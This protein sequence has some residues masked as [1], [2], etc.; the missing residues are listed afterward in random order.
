MSTAPQNAVDPI[1]YE[2]I[3]HRLWSI[4]EEGATTIAHASG[5]PVVHASDYNFGI[6]TRDGE[7]AVSG[8]FYMIPIYVMQEVIRVIRERFGD[9]IHPGDVFVINDPFVAGVHQND[10]QFVA[11][12]FHD[13]ELVG[14][15]GCMAHLM[16]VG[17]ALP[18]SWCPGAK[19]VY[20][21]GL[22]VPAARIVDRG[23]LV[24]GV[25]DMIVAN[26]RLPA[27]VA[28]DMSAFLSAHRVAQK[29]LTEACE[30]YGT[31][32]IVATLEQTLD[33]T[34]QSMREWL[35]RLPDGR[36][37]HQIYIDHDGH[38][39]NLY[40]IVCTLEKTGDEM[41]FDFAGTDPAIVGLGNATTTG[42]YGS[43]GSAILAIFGSSLPWNGGLVRPLTVTAPE[44]SVVSAER[45]MPI[46]AGSTGA[47]YHVESAALT[48]F[49]KLLAFSADDQ[50]YVCGPAD[51]SWLLASM[52]GVNQYGE[53]YAGMPMDPLGWGGP[54][55]S[56]RDGVDT[57]GAMFIPGGGFADV[58]T[59]EAG[60]PW[61]YLWRRENADSGGAGRQRGGN[62]IDACIALY[63]T[64]TPST[65][66]GA[67][68]GVVVPNTIGVFG[69]Y[70][71]ATTRS[72]HIGAG[73]WREQLA[74]GRHPSGPEQIAGRHTT[75]E[76]KC[77]TQMQPG[78]L[79]VLHTQN[80]GGFGDPLE[81]DPAVVASDV[82]QGH[83]SAEH[84]AAIYGVVVDGTGEVD[85][86]A[87]A[88]R[89]AE[90]RAHR[91]ATA[92]NRRDD[93]AVRDDLEVVARWGDVIQ[94]VRDGDG[95]AV[96]SVR[97]GAVLG[98]LGDNWRDVA[99]W[100]AV[101]PAELG[102]QIVLD[103]R[104]ELRQYVDPVDGRSLWVD[105]HRKGDPL[106]VD[107]R[108]APEALR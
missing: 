62:G 6:Y 44:N 108:L 66:V 67:T 48:C 99:P 81:R 5:S 91:I 97:S 78:D 58:E 77:T 12:F 42:T 73:D 87:T 28:N 88:A 43:V 79:V 22:L 39:N 24:E 90:L 9:A 106:T 69:A 85:A 53:P 30:Q 14:W 45:P 76:A 107:F 56:F 94:I 101:D 104:M 34:E 40:R 95:L 19:E 2:V 10:M 86:E 15:T 47:T 96:Q 55:F 11:P 1:T 36:F 29:R 50:E 75:L 98:P 18:G 103:E 17:G 83:A 93:Y 54:A 64:E 7:L 52:G 82:R 60:H 105:L 71:G 74:A 37:Q 51:G 4:N 49:G 32:A 8:V 80:A 59:V 33:R 13:G 89:R 61:L 70:P 23:R 84:A 21:E 68:M 100:R 57:G 26:T 31:A 27:M 92:G 63:D 3:A 20:E 46:S 16:D 72:D 35:A 38:E 41:R 102:A 25:W 65:M